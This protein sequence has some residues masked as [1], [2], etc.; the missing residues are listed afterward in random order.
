MSRRTFRATLTVLSLAPLYQL[1]GRSIPQSSLL[2][3][4]DLFAPRAIDD[5]KIASQARAE[6]NDRFV[7]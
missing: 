5:M 4:R 3:T 2:S 1:F 7:A 6:G